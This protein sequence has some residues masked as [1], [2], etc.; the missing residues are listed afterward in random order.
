[1]AYYAIAVVPPDWEPSKPLSFSDTGYNE[2]NGHVM[3]GTRVLIYKP[4]PVNAIVAEAEVPDARFLRLDEWPAANVG[5][6]LRTGFGAAATHILP[7]RV[8]YTRDDTTHI[9]LDTVREYLEDE[10]FPTEEWHVIEQTA[11]QSLTNW[12]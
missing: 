4:A 1:M 10:S 9:P 12:P 11:Y 3:A 6:A 8:L 2:W 7:L 5:E